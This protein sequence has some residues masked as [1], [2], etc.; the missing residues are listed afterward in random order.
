MLRGSSIRASVAAAATSNVAAA[1][2]TSAAPATPVAPPPTSGTSSRKAPKAHVSFRPLP[3]QS[4]QKTAA[5]WST[6][7][8]PGNSNAVELPQGVSLLGETL[9]PRPIIVLGS[10]VATLE[11][12]AQQAES[13]SHSLSQAAWEHG[14][15]HVP[16]IATGATALPTLLRDVAQ[17]VVKLLDV[18][19]IG[20]MHTLGHSLG[21]LVAAKMAL[22]FPTRAG[23]LMLLDSQLLDKQWIANH[24]S[25]DEIR[26]AQDDV[27]VPESM[28]D[29]R[30]TQLREGLEGPLKTGEAQQHDAAI[31]ADVL[32]SNSRLFGASNGMTRCD[33]SYLSIDELRILRHPLQLIVPAPNGVCDVNTHKDFFNLR[34]IQPIKS[35]Q[36]HAAL[37]TPSSGTSAGIAEEVGSMIEQWVQRYEPDTIMARRY[38]TAVKDMNSKMGSTT[39]GTPS[40]AAASAE[41]EGGKKSKKDKKEK[42]GKPQQPASS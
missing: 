14:A 22:D 19:G 33:A 36:S 11:A 5:L 38:E 29:F 16:I 31:F 37:F 42:K 6:A 32:F 1:E 21:A 28:L 23:T 3:L 41:A 2:T 25:R 27:N 12:A 7:G 10:A 9:G 8:A 34:R 26:K 4:W 40:G 35:A 24:K 15:I 20:W 18:L 39:G 30:I 13:F 17:Q